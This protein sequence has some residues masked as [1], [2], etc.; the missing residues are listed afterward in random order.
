METAAPQGF[1]STFTVLEPEYPPT[2]TRV[3]EYEFAHYH[4]A[5]T[6]WRY[7]QFSAVSGGR[8][9]NGRF[10]SGRPKIGGITSIFALA[11]GNAAVVILAGLGYLIRFDEPPRWNPIEVPPIIRAKVLTEDRAVALASY[12][13]ITVCGDSNVICTLEGIS[14]DGVELGEA[15]KGLLEA[16][17][18]SGNKGDETLGIDLRTGKLVKL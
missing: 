16:K 6:E 9:W 1:P 13:G 2:G 18:W 17:V 7:L 15:R 4:E 8:T 3:A 12:T 5:A 14:A 10:K 11:D